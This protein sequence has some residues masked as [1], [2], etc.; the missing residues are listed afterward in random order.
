[1][2]AETTTD[3]ELLKMVRTAIADPGQFFPREYE[4]R[5]GERIYETI[6]HWGARAVLAVI[7]DEAIDRMANKLAAIDHM[8]NKLA[9]ETGIRSMDFRNG[10]AMELEPSRALV[11]NWVGAARGMLG[12]A[13]NYSETPI[14]MTVKV[15]EDPEEF[16][17]ILQ[18]VGPGKLTPHQ[19]RVAA[20]KELGQLRVNAEAVRKLHAP[21]QYH[22][23]LSPWCTYCNRDDNERDDVVLW[24]CPTL[25]AL[26]GGETP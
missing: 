8:A 6:S 13:P 26:D 4:D 22:D 9:D 1:M 3:A 17:F 21:E 10:M 20:E 16:V 18:R 24:P 15:A 2:T 25:I 19:A 14:T 12:D 5:D 7:E 23:E 11:A